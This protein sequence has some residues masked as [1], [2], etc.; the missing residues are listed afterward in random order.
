MLIVVLICIMSIKN[1]LIFIVSALVSNCIFAQSSSSESVIYKCINNGT[2]VISNRKINKSCQ[3]IIYKK[4]KKNTAANNTQ[5]KNKNTAANHNNNSSNNSNHKNTEVA[6]VVR[7]KSKNNITNN[8]N[9][10]YNYNNSNNSV[11]SYENNFTNHN[12]TEYPKISPQTQKNRD[13]DRNFI[14]NQ[15]LLYELEALKKAESELAVYNDKISVE[16]KIN[17]RNKIERHQR[18]ITAIRRELRKK[19]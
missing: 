17:Y 12:K 4:I 11:Y 14:L 7:T 10:F 6:S 5:I 2:E 3:P 8:Y 9:N 16:E 15:E 13:N 19:R 1:L 18:N